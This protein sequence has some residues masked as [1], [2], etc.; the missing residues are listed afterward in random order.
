M[1]DTPEI[2]S[3]LIGRTFMQ[4]TRYECL[5]PSEQRCGVPQPPMVLP[6]DAAAP[7]IALPPAAELPVASVDLRA[8]IEGRRSVRDYAPEPLALAELSYL[9]W[10]T[11]G[12]LRTIASVTLRTVPSA[13]ARHALESYLLINRVEG[14]APG[15]YRYLPLE[16]AL[17]LV[18][19]SGAIAP[20]VAQACLGQRMLTDCAV[21]FLWTA[22]VAR[23]TW[24][25]S[26]RGY[27]Y[28]H[29]DAGHVCQ[30]LHLAAEA[31]GCGVC[32][33][34]AFDDDA[35][36]EVL[37]LDGVEQFAIYLATVGRKVGA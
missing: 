31:I 27:R 33:I 36:N 5:P 34:A 19:E 15:L 8:L 23:M 29:L 7:R 16:H 13:G 6:P 28:L 3:A 21:A 18:P 1:A 9:L 24:R 14:L 11:Q 12:V 20:F 4:Q 17:Q 30:N 22:V 37:G 25:Y 26:Q 32:A 2:P 35:L 10:C